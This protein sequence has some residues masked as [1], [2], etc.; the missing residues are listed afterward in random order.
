MAEDKSGECN[1][2]FIIS[3]GGIQKLFLDGIDNACGTVANPH[4]VMTDISI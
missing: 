3:L 1:R 2:Q 4:R